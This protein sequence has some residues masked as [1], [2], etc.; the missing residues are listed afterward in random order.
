MGFP[1]PIDVLPHRPPF[2]FVDE[3]VDQQKAIEDLSLETLQTYSSLIGPDV[4][5]AISLEKCVED[6]S[7]PGGPGPASVQMII[8]ESKA[9]FEALQV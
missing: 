1:A 7:L 9:F 2:L 4:Y 5:T 3:V 8:R 6:R